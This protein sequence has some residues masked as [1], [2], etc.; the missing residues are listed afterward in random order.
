LALCSPSRG[1]VI[2]VGAGTRT[3]DRSATGQNGWAQVANS[4]LFGVGRGV[5]FSWATGV[6]VAVGTGGSAAVASSLDG[7]LS[8]TGRGTSVL[9]SAYGVCWGSAVWVAVGSGPYS[10]ATSLDGASWTGQA[11][12]TLFVTGY[13]VAYGDGRYVAVGQGPSQTIATSAPLPSSWTGLGPFQPKAMPSP[14]EQAG[15]WPL[16]KGPIPLP[17]RLMD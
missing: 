16:E 14:M 1:V 17:S 10:I 6:W 3:V 5:A 2:A 9:L 13:G 4:S 8:W 11:G 15:G 12:S 7:G